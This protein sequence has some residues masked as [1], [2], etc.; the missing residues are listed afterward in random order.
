VDAEDTPGG[1]L[2]MLVTVPLAGR[3]P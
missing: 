1:G 2:T 3:T